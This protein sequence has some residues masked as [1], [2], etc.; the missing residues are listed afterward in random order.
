MTK[1][2]ITV[3][4][5]VLAAGVG[6]T[7]FTLQHLKKEHEILAVD[8]NGNIQQ[9]VEPVAPKPAPVEVKVEPDPVTPPAPDPDAERAALFR[10]P[11]KLL[12]AFADLAKNRDVDAFLELAGPDAI[13]AETKLRLVE[14]LK[15]PAYQ[16]PAD[17]PVI[18]L[19]RVGDATRYAL[20]FH[21]VADATPASAPEAT[22]SNAPQTSPATATVETPGT[23]T[24]SA[25]G[26]A[27]DPAPGTGAV[28]TA[29]SPTETTP[30]TGTTPAPAELSPETLAA[31]AARNSQPQLPERQI[32]IDLR[33]P[34]RSQKVWEIAKILVPE[35]LNLDPNSTSILPP[36]TDSVTVA[37]HFAKAVLEGDFKTAR[38]LTDADKITDERIA[39]LMIAVEEGDYSLHDER[40][41]TQ[42]LERETVSWIIAK[43]KN[44]N[45]VS[46][47][48]LEMS[49][50]DPEKG[51][52]IDGMSFD[53]I[54]Q[55]TSAAGGGGGVAYA[56]IVKNPQGGDSL[57]LFFDFDGDKLNVRAMQQV[58]IIASILKT[59]PARQIT[60]NGHADALGLDDYNT[61]LSARRAGA[62]KRA[63]ID[64]GVAVDQV[65]T[66]G[67]GETAPLSPNFKPDGSDN[68]NGRSQN[69]RTE[70]YLNF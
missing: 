58:E 24:G 20:Q 50:L 3:F 57:V 35:P 36:S 61:Q 44:A 19:A 23:A 53:K 6:T 8:D 60:I 51:W 12:G 52:R 26:P 9:P 68:P 2:Q 34:D 18:S 14:L 30:P 49:K 11:E 64:L 16:P 42:T 38:A 41:L 54:I 47:F 48:G 7:I 28:E 43:V 22:P 21:P 32:Y 67:F 13:D 4:S 17:N 59:N 1:A 29:P 69:R 65:I 46:E 56:P 10:E 15:N 25:A 31:P 70:V 39:A 5:V 63:I 55:M 66:K 27:T 45:V 33:Q 40:P 37:Y 62:V